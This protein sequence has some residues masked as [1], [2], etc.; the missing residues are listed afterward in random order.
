MVADTHTF[1]PTTVLD[2]RLGYNRN[3]IINVPEAPGGAAATNAFIQDNGIQG[4]PGVYG[5]P[6]YPSENI[7][8]FASINQNGNPF[9]DDK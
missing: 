6:L 3:Y 4:L 1:N 5:I 8:G 2:V 7:G 9:V